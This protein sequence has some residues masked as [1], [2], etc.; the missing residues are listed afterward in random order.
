MKNNAYI[1][2][3]IDKDREKLKVWK[4]TNINNRINKLNNIWNFFELNESYL[5]ECDFSFFSRLEKIIHYSIYEY[6]IENLDNKEWHTEFFRIESLEKIFQRLK[7]LKIEDKFIHKWIK[8]KKVIPIKNNKELKNNENLIQNNK[9]I[10]FLKNLIKSNNTLR[11]NKFKLIK[12]FENELERDEFI[13]ELFKHSVY[14]HIWKTSEL[15]FAFYTCSSYSINDK[16]KLLIDINE[17]FE[18]Y[19]DREWFSETIKKI[20]KVLK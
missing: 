2:I 19:E 4:S 18:K 14:C 20:K 13:N 17:S 9:N 12:K 1:Y 5:I 16:L 8:I 6:R 11:E 10:E 15:S 7:E 3:L